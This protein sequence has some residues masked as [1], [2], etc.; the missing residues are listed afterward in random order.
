MT[1]RHGL[2]VAL[3]LGLAACGRGTPKPPPPSSMQA[4]A[5][6][7]VI[8][9]PAGSPKLGQIQLAEVQLADMPTDEFTV[10]GRIVMNPNRVS[11][12]LL[13]VAG[14][15]EIGRAHV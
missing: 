15:V 9:I 13:P 12:V 3:A 6:P 7:S 8:E 14:R 11:K 5:D 1:S 10:P 2:V 4:P